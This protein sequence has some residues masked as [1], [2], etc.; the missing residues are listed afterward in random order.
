MSSFVLPSLLIFKSK[1]SETEE[2]ADIFEVRAQ[3][4]TKVMLWFLF[5]VSLPLV[6]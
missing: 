2:I 4:K 6:A 5:E 1:S 3:Y